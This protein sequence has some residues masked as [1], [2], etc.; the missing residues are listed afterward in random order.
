MK[1]GLISAWVEFNVSM[2]MYK[3][4]EY[5]RGMVYFGINNLIMIANGSL[6]S[7]LRSDKFNE[8]VRI[9]RGTYACDNV[10]L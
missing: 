2:S 10:Q 4:S 8:H 3:W 1:F 5:Q 9:F 6:R 7:R